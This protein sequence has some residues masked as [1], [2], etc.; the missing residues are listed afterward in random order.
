MAR[1]WAQKWTTTG[2]HGVPVA[3]AVLPPV[4]STSDNPTGG[5]DR[6]RY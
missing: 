2:T 3:P 4:R 6:R 1:D 5:K